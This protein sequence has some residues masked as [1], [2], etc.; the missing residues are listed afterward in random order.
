[1]LPEFLD[2]E[3]TCKSVGVPFQLAALDLIYQNVS[4]IEQPLFEE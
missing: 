2:E 3:T 4:D 1:M